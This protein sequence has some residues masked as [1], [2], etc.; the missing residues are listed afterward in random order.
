MKAS[1]LKDTLLKSPLLKAAA[2]I[3]L[4][5]PAPAFSVPGVGGLGLGNSPIAQSIRNHSGPDQED[6]PAI[7]CVKRSYIDFSEFSIHHRIICYDSDGR[8]RDPITGK[9]YTDP[10]E[11][12]IETPAPSTTPGGIE[13]S[14]A[15]H[16][17]LGQLSTLWNSYQGDSRYSLKEQL[18]LARGVGLLQRLIFE[19]ARAREARH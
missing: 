12:P 6:L 17:T 3:V 11:N 14:P 1:I 18:E 2:A 16:E 10:V 15:E 4:V 13:L 9:P 7:K 19:R 5:L 8:T